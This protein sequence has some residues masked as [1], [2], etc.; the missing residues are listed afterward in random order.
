M[1]PVDPIVGRVI[2]ARG[3]R[4]VG[5]VLIVHLPVVQGRSRLNPEKWGYEGHHVP[6][7]SYLSYYFAR[8]DLATPLS[9]APAALW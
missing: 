8:H 3:A 2:V 6:C 5:H 9:Q 1:V 7:M 4:L